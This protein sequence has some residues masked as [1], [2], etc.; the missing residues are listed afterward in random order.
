MKFRTRKIGEAKLNQSLH[1]QLMDANKPKQNMKRVVIT[2]LIV[3]ALILA[4]STSYFFY[5]YQQ[6]KRQYQNNATIQQVKQIT[7]EVSKLMLLPKNETPTIATVNDVTKLKD[8]PF[9]TNAKNGDKVLIYP[10]ARIAI[11]Y[12]PTLHLIIN[13]SPITLGNNTQPQQ[14][15]TPPISPTPTI[16]PK[17][18]PTPIPTQANQ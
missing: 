10:N 6:L 5:Q 4:A 11:L 3:I 8:Q 18:S 16:R 7:T 12:N 15:P 2:I 17:I 14:I 13:V 1:T 9:F